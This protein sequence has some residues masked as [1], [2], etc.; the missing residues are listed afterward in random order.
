MPTP[1]KTELKKRLLKA[2]Q[3]DHHALC[4]LLGEELV[5]ID[6]ADWSAQLMYASSLCAFCDYEKAYQ[7]IDRAQ[8]HIPKEKIYLIHIRRGNLL[9]RQGRLPEAEKQYLKSHQTRPDDASGLIFAGS[10]AFCRGNLDTAVSHL[11][12][13]IQCRD[14]C[15]DEAY[16]NLGGYLLA[17]HQYEEARICYLKALEID[18]DYRQAKKQL[19]DLDQ[20]LKRLM[21]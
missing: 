19:R 6:P 20:T 13:A 7:A 10:V 8:A 12:K 14:G 2:Y 17:K 15:I 5:R 1:K 11:R 3:K 21:A 9:K 16:Y 4:R 18:P